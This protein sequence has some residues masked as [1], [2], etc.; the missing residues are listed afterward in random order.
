M[1]PETA[2]RPETA[3]EREAFE[4]AFR[5]TSYADSNT[6]N[7]YPV[8]A[9]HTGE[10]IDNETRLMWQGFRYGWASRE[11]QPV[12]PQCHPDCPYLRSLKF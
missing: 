4:A 5:R 1:K 8:D 2:Y 6:L 9:T 3:G 10:Y 7:R 12:A 11:A